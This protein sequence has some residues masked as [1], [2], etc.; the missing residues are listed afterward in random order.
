MPSALVAMLFVMKED[1]ATVAERTVSK[2]VTD[3]AAGA[4]RVKVVVMGQGAG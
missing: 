2:Y 3:G 4:A 1:L